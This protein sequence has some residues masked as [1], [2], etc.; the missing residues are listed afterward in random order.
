MSAGPRKEAWAARLRQVIADLGDLNRDTERD[1]LAIGGK[2][3]GFMQAVKVVSSELTALVNLLSGECS[4][5]ASGALTSALHRAREMSAGADVS[6][7]LLAGMRNEAGRLW[8]TLSG[9]EGTVS[10]FHTIGVLTRVETA[11]LG[12]GAD[13]GN[14]AE[15]VR[16]LA[17]DIQARIESAL[18]TSAELIPTIE[19]VLNQVTALEQEQAHGLPPV[20]AGVLA[21]LASFRDIQTRMHGASV[22]LAARYDAIQAAFH[23]L[24]VSIQFHDITRQQVE[25]V[26]ETLE[27]L[28]AEPVPP[29]DTAGLLELQSR[30][31]ADAGEKFSASVASIVRN[32]DG[33]AESVREMAGGSRGLWGLS[34]DEKN[35]FLLELERGLTAILGGFSGC[36]EAERATRVASGGMTETIGRMRRSLE[37]IRTI[38][39]KMQRLALNASIRAD[40]IG[41]P[42]NVLGVLADAMQ[43]L[44][45]ECAQRSASLVEALGSMSQAAT[46][47]SG[48]DGPAPAGDPGTAV[49]GMRTAVA[50][51]HSWCERSFAQI[52]GIAAHSA[53]LSEDL[54]A[55][56]GAFSVGALFAAAIGRARGALREI[57][58]ETPSGWPA[59]A[60]GA[61]PPGLADFARH[62]TMQAEREVHQAVLQPMA[63]AVP[64][65]ALAN[66]PD[67]APARSGTQL[68]SPA[69]LQIS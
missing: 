13:F 11:R 58:G 4:T 16:L 5:S 39:I 44:A 8:Q 36:A 23:N 22:G 14:L 15:D 67:P 9:F 28:C 35:S 55:A 45:S 7:G 31:L 69:H 46:R 24:V 65:G 17:G 32:L 6:N 63:P 18:D 19:S 21:S 27:R 10:T 33:I 56:R 51:M 25:H 54:A 2:L 57:A 26:R 49:E 64:A 20:I 47:L 66:L 68:C 34:E 37:E 40:H 42:G 12:A 29:S 30:Q 3:T 52:A 61:S 1:F 50:G 62:Y 53:S 60:A 43:K 48:Q 59:G 41:A 38:E